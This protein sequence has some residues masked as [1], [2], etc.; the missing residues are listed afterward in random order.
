MHIPIT[1]GSVRQSSVKGKTSP[2]V[3]FM[4]LASTS[5]EDTDSVSPYPNEGTHAQLV[6]SGL[7]HACCHSILS[8]VAI[9]FSFV[10]NLLP[11]ITLPK[12]KVQTFEAFVRNCL[13]K[14]L[15]LDECV[16]RLHHIPAA[17]LYNR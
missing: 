14:E 4:G 12:N 8:L 16:E 13:D 6:C 15:I 5:M 2:T 3:T 1:I 17:I 7:A 10:S 11:Y 9:L